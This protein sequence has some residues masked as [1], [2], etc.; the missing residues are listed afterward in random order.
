MRYFTATLTLLVLL[1]ATPTRAQ[2][3]ARMLR[4]P[5]VSETQISCP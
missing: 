5:D 3:D 2:I 4:H 1:G